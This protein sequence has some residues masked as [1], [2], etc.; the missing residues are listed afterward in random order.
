MPARPP[1]CGPSRTPPISPSSV[2]PHQEPLVPTSRNLDE[3]PDDQDH[4]DLR[5]LV[6]SNPGQ[7]TFEEYRA[8]KERIVARAP[9][10]LLVFGVG[11]DSRV[12]VGANRGG[13]TVFVEHEP[14]WIAR[15][16]EELPGVAIH[17]VRYD[18]RRLFG[19][20]LLERRDR[21]FMEDLPESVMARNW[22][23]IFVDSPQ[24]VSW[25]RPGRM[26]SIYTASVLARRSTDVDVFVHDCHRDIENLYSERYLGPER[27][28][29]QE[30]TLRHFHLRPT[31]SV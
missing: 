13:R 27:L 2:R 22:D 12:W 14:E 17:P 20:R 24:G 9:C 23:I 30:G 5:E 3:H 18:T 11:R 10:D 16:R 7:G 31:L 15:T 19:K 25:R 8:L 4:P 29:R 28:V 26:K 21:L 1:R 6:R